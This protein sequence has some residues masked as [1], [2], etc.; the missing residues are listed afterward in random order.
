MF[1]FYFIFMRRK[2]SLF[3]VLDSIVNIR[4]WLRLFK[5]LLNSF[6]VFS[7]KNMMKMSS[8][9]LVYILNSTSLKRPVSNLLTN[10]LAKRGPI[11]IQ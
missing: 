3:D 7:L 6:A 9:Y 11:E 1:P 5:F 4:S 2:G 8:T 10:H